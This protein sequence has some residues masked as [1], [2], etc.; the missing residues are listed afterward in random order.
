MKKF[1]IFAASALL[2]MGVV[3]AQEDAVSMEELLNQ[4]QQGQ[5]RDSQEARE[6]EARFAQQRN[7]QQ[8]LLNQA[9]AERTRQENTS[10]RLEQLFNENQQRIIDPG[11]GSTSVSAP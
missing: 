11:H 7:E 1:A 5:A 9:R 2:T 10:Q 4:I 8:N 3:Q 6:R